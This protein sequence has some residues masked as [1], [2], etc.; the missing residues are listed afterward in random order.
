MPAQAAVLAGTTSMP[1][2]G[3][4]PSSARR[5]GR[6]PASSDVAAARSAAEPARP[7]RPASARPGTGGRSRPGSSAA[8][9]ARR[10]G[11]PRSPRRTG[12]AARRPRTAYPTPRRPRRSTASARLRPYP[13]HSGGQS[14]HPPVDAHRRR[15]APAAPEQV[16]RAGRAARPGRPARRRTA[17]CPT[18]PL[19]V[20][21]A[22]LTR[23]RSS[24]RDDGVLVDERHRGQHQPDP[25]QPAQPDQRAEP[26]EQPERHHVHHVDSAQRERHPVARR[27]AAHADRAVDLGVLAGVDQVEAADPQADGGAEHPGRPGAGERAGDARARRRPARPAAPAPRIACGQSV[28]RLAY[29]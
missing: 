21:N 15:G 4:E 17:R 5:P 1:R 26:D 6:R 13:A 16:R 12:R 2:A 28:N 3:Y 20:K 14:G 25:P 7:G 8:R 18:N 29:G 19:A 9:P 11:R 24:R 27:H 10:R 23:D 22:R